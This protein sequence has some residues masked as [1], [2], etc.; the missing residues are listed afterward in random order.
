M[1]QKSYLIFFLAALTGFSSLAQEKESLFNAP[2]T[3]WRTERITFP[4]SFAPTL[5]YEGFEDILFA[6]GWADSS[7]Q[8]FWTYAFVW[9]VEYGALMSEN[10]LATSLETYYNGLMKA[11]SKDSSDVDRLGRTLCLFIKTDDG[12]SGK[13]RVFDAFFS[14][15]EIT[16][17]V[18][19]QERICRRTNKQIVYF[20][21]SPKPFEDS[22]WNI[23]TNIS[24]NAPCD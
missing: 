12:F 5:Q 11:V 6:P 17:H 7:S 9:Y 13:M 16:L 8:Q 15:K 23:F 2:D 22:V 18:K 24:L 14:K 21:I 20:E 4:L 19:V 1:F 10:L 3:T